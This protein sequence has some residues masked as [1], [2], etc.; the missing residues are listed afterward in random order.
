MP[1]TS[2]R[3]EL[4]SVKEQTNTI[5]AGC[6]KTSPEASTYSTPVACLPSGAVRMRVTTE[7]VR[8]SNPSRCMTAGRIVVCGEDLE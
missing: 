7:R 2:S 1:E 8:N 3:C 6:I 4:A 5:S